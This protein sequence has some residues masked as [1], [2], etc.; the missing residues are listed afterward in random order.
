MAGQE[1][2][3]KSKLASTTVSNS[4]GGIYGREGLYVWAVAALTMISQP[5]RRNYLITAAIWIKG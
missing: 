4:L 5:G 2:K 1:I 3:S